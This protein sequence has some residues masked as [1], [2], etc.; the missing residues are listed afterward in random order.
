MFY[1]AFCFCCC[2][3]D[4]T[5]EQRILDQDV[6]AVLF[7]NGGTP[8]KIAL[9]TPK[10]LELKTSIFERKIQIPQSSD[11]RCAKTRKNSGKT[12]KQLV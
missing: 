4:A 7:F 8:M 2:F 10:K 6:F 1:R 5:A 11:G 3:F 9:I 12:T